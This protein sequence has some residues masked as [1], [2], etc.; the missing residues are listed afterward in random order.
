MDLFFVEFQNL[1][2]D[3][4]VKKLNAAL[5]VTLGSNQM[6][7]FKYAGIELWL[8]FSAL[9]DNKLKLQKKEE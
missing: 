1:I 6:S 7:H 9:S 3:Q 4:R 5:S 8:A 2:F